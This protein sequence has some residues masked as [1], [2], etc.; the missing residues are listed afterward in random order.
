MNH[1]EK[2]LMAVNRIAVETGVEPED[3]H[4]HK[5]KKEVY[6]FHAKLSEQSILF[7]TCFQSS[8]FNLPERVINH[9]ISIYYE[10]Y[11]SRHNH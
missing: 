11:R 4:K 8:L 3:L 1:T 5:P 10:S 6:E 7:G 2:M 9:R